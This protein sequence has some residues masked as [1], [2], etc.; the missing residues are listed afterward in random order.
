MT[1]IYDYLKQEKELVH[2]IN[3]LRIELVELHRMRNLDESNAWLTTD[4][5]ALRATNDKMRGAAV[6][7]IMNEFPNTYAQK[8]AEF[9]NLETKLKYVRNVIQTMRDFGDDEIV[10]DFGHDKDKRSSDTAT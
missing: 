7:Q 2:Q 6:K 4:F 1:T 9:E 5:K 3:S 10:D 8:K